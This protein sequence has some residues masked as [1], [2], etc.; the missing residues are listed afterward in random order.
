MGVFLAGSRDMAM[1]TRTVQILGTTHPPRKPDRE[2]GTSM[3]GGTRLLLR[4]SLANS[5]AGNALKFSEEG[6]PPLGP[7][8]SINI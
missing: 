4:G 5:T 2:E 8:C 6:G 3:E 1:G 7:I